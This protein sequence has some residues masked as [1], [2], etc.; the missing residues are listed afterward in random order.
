MR[1]EW[2]R[3]FVLGGVSGM[4]RVWRGKGDGDGEEKRGEEV[5]RKKGMR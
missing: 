1:G 3:V 4:W 2:G 5:V